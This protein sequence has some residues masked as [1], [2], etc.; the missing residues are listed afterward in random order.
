VQAPF[1]LLWGLLKSDHIMTHASIVVLP[2]VAIA[3]PSRV[4][5]VHCGLDCPPNPPQLGEHSFCCNGC[6]TVYQILSDNGLGRF[7]TIDQ[8]P[9]VRPPETLPSEYSALDQPDVRRRVVDFSNGTMTR[10]TFRIPA[11]HCA[12]CVWLLENLYR[13]VPGVGRS[14]VNFPRKEVSIQLEDKDVS[15]SAL[16]TR[17]ASLGYPPELK[18]DRLSGLAD[19]TGHRRL[20]LQVGIAGFAFGNV[21]MMSFPS[22]LGLD[23]VRDAGLYRT[24]GYLSLA[25]ALPVLF[26]SAQDF[27]RAAW[28]GLRQ[29]VLTIDFPLALGISALFI[30]S[31]FDILRHTGEGFLDSF[32]GLVFLLLCGKWFQRRTYDAL[33]FDRDYRSYFPLSVT[34][35]NNGVD[36]PAVLTDIKPGDR[37]LVRHGEIIPADAVLISGQGNLDYSF[38]TGESTPANAATGDYVYAGG[39]QIGGALEVELV[40]DVSQSY[41]TSL[42]NNEAF[43]KPREMDWQNLTNRAGRWFTIAVVLVA[44]G[45]ALFWWKH[46]PSMIARTFSAVLIVAC[47][48]ALALAA[49][50]TFSTAQRHL[51]KAG[52]FLRSPSVVEAMAASNHVVFD[53]TGTLTHGPT[54]TVEFEGAPLT[55]DERAM[56]HTLTS[57]SSHPV[58]RAVTEF[59]RGC[60]DQRDAGPCQ[61]LINF[62]E[63]TGSGICGQVN[64]HTLRIGSASWLGIHAPDGYGTWITIDEN[65][66]GRFLIGQQERTGLGSLIDTMHRDHYKI[67]LL[68]GDRPTAEA[69]F[70]TLFGTNAELRF[71][72]SPHD[73][74]AFVRER[75]ERGESVLMMGDGLNDAGALKQSNVGIAVSDNV[76]LFSPACD[77]ILAGNAF[78]RL[79]FFLHFS[80]LSVTVLKSAFAV[81]LI[82]NI[83]GVAFAASGALS[84]LVS[85]VL[86]PLSSFSVIGFSLLATSWAAHRSGVT[87]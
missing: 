1:V 46:D 54:G 83:T 37:I 5:C 55:D 47:P 65:V 40:K 17:L 15:L 23:P 63:I 50:F 21:M 58:S 3:S 66:R 82:Y 81:S 30:Q 25:L 43:Q 16:A 52:L 72:Q 86:M 75:Q 9:G 87:A 13:L 19:T 60:A 67:T 42:W 61:T 35:R 34:R 38:V 7:Y 74:L 41:L 31:V 12:A 49:P 62:I 48:C 84:P 77:A 8:A 32:T 69:R 80:R 85:A 57:Q 53:K 24:F 59:L 6:L 64:G 78:A 28:N 71:D 44:S 73:K 76:T 27:Y 11:M 14:E 70:R 26:F 33:A 45:T 10:V 79:P 4:A 29:K 20:L 51:G 56:I 2:D 36:E 22:Y 68:S 39:R 18:L